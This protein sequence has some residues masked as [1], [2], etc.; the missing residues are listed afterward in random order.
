MANVVPRLSRTPGSIRWAGTTA[1][2]GDREAIL[3]EV[4]GVRSPEV[5]GAGR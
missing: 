5:P 4:D 3:R 2:G 1:I